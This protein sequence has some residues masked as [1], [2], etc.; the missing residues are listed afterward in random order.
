MIHRRF[1]EFISTKKDFS[2]KDSL[3]ILVIF[4]LITFL[5]LVNHEMWRDEIQAWLLARDSSSI[6]N[7]FSNLK[8]EGHTPLWHLLLFPLA[9]MNLPIISMQLLGWTIGLLIAAVILVQSPFSRAEKLLFIFGYY[10]FYEYV[11]LSRNYGISLLFLFLSLNLF[12]KKWNFLSLFLLSLSAL[13][14]IFSLILS[15]VLGLYFLYRSDAKKIFS[16][17]FFSGG[18]IYFFTLS[19]CFLLLFPPD[20][21]AF[22][23]TSE[24]FVFDLDRFFTVGYKIAHAFLPFTSVSLEYFSWNTWSLNPFIALL[25]FLTSVSFLIRLYYFSAISFLFLVLVA[26]LFFVFQYTIYPAS[27]LRHSGIFLGAFIIFYWISILENEKHNLSKGSFIFK[28]NSKLYF[29]SLIFSAFLSIYA[30]SFDYIYK[31]SNA[32]DAA[33]FLNDNL[34]SV[35]GA[36]IFVDGSSEGS[37]VIGHAN[38]NQAFYR[39]GMRYGSFNRWDSERLIEGKLSQIDFSRFEIL[40]MSYKLDEIPSNFELVAEFAEM[41][42][43]NENFYIYLKKGLN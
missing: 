42:P 40:L 8:Y 36:K 30:L 39:Q 10:F 5:V 25:I 4:T 17:S 16:V 32:K 31:F 22:G 27:S 41:N 1:F 13:S 9:K 6:I 14:N 29:A 35:D 3:K 23:L 43:V 18:L 12:F 15:S 38:Y 37:S 19:F 7:L 26:F 33:T 11:I 28:L 34:S 2:S 24:N 20:D 21:R